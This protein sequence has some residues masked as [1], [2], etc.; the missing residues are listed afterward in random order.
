MSTDTECVWFSYHL[1]PE[2]APRVSFTL[3]ADGPNWRLTIGEVCSIF[4]THDQ[5]ARL[6][7]DIATVTHAAPAPAS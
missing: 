7:D 2:A 1:P 6:V 4:G 5:L 3:S